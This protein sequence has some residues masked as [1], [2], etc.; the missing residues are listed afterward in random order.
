MRR[1]LL[2]SLAIIFGSIGLMAGYVMWDYDPDDV[3]P[4]VGGPSYLS[5]FEENV[6][7]RMGKAY[8]D[9]DDAA[10]RRALADLLSGRTPLPARE[11][12]L[13]RARELADKDGALELLKGTLN[14]QNDDLYEVAIA[15]IARL[16]TPKSGA[17]LDSLHRAL[18]AM[19]AAHTPLGD[20]RSS[21]IIISRADPDLAI[22][23]QEQSR[24]DADYSV[25][26]ASEISFFFPAGPEYLLSVPNA[27]DVL[28]DYHDSRFAKA[29]EG[30]PVP[31]DAW[32]LPMLRT[33]GALRKRL[34]ETMGMMAP[35]FDPQRLFRDQLMIGKYDDEYL[36]ASF[37]D[38]N[39]EVAE[40]MMT[41][42]SKLGRDFGITRTTV[43]GS[44]ISTV[45]NLKTGRTLNYAVVGDY[46]IVATDTALIGRAVR[47]YGSDRGS[48]IA[49]DPVFNRNF[50]ALD[51]SGRKDVLF[52]WFD[53]TD[54][55]EVDGSKDPAGRRLAA[56]SRA[57]G[58]TIPADQSHARA[59][60]AASTFPGAIATSIMTGDD[61]AMFWRYVV[62]VRSLG[63]SPLDSL[64]RIARV[65]IGRQIVPYFS[66][67]MALGYGGVDYLARQYGYSHTAFD[68]LAAMPLNAPPP[69][70][71]STLKTFFGGITSLVYTQEP[72][73]GGTGRLWIASDTTTND[74]LLR[75]RKLQP[76]FAVVND[77]TLLVASTPELLR[78]AAT[79]LAARDAAAAT[80]ANTYLNGIVQVDSFATNATEYLSE[81]LRRTGRYS[82]SE[83]SERIEPLGR[84]LG[85]YRTLAWGFQAENGLRHGEMRLSPKQ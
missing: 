51:Q 28:E 7:Q 5:I 83:I 27:D 17:F 45:R 50:S 65:D 72:L 66:R 84:A 22:R 25:A 64:A 47:T 16:G 21:T 2:I 43:E 20:Y 63:K 37:K 1:F 52:A 60:G 70:F 58:R 48:S 73:S 62:D 12:A 61:P 29:L 32:S 44:T 69:R 76:S 9:L 6:R 15:S 59:A 56:V 81:Y 82:P 41:I 71:D 40:T 3:S 13:F 39:V 79:A 34:D 31:R 36:V 14:G 4:T 49:I 38:K 54:Y 67:S 24:V 78:R 68:M 75:E 30:S 46:F 23:F 26:E 10:R 53:P 57:L 35:Y 8:A 55:F 74:S 18:D 11:V 77:R 85:I 33:I 19:P 42:F 80:P